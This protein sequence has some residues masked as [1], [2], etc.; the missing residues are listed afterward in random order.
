MKVFLLAPIQARPDFDDV[1]RF[2][3]DTV[4][5]LGHTIDADY[6]FKVTE[7]KLREWAETEIDNVHDMHKKNIKSI[8]QSN[9]VIAEVSHQRFSIGYFI[10]L[11]LEWGKPVIVLYK[12]GLHFS[13][14]Q[15]LESNDLLVAYEYDSLEDL[16]DNLKGLLEYSANRHD[17]RFNFFIS[18]KQ[19]LYLDWVSRQRRIPRSV[20]LR[21]LIEEYR[22]R[23]TDD[24]IS[25]A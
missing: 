13:L 22:D 19:Q 9:V 16:G 5:G 25:A 23:D 11:A 1:F 7:E 15:T 8:K 14:L 3:V 10:S 6:L 21:R 2:I 4:K 24:E 17:T 20:F 12:K 18:P